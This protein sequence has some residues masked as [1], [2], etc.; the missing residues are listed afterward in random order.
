MHMYVRI[1]DLYL[2]L[3]HRE[4][5]V[6]RRIHACMYARIRTYMYVRIGDLYL[7]LARRE[8]A[9]D[10]ALLAVQQPGVVGSSGKHNARSSGWCTS[11]RQGDKETS[12]SMRVEQ[13]PAV[14]QPPALSFSKVSTLVHLLHNIS[15]K[16]TFQKVMHGHKR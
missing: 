2:Q 13:T 14:R 9:V 15:I 3:A 11:R 8:E 12:R 10:R 6:R 1:G 4:E 16:R 5:A 7:Q